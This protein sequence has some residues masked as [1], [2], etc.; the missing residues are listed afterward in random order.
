MG[1]YSFGAPRSLIAVYS[2]ACTAKSSSRH[3]PKVMLHGIKRLLHA[4]A[5]RCG[6]RLVAHELLDQRILNAE[7]SV[8]LQIL[9]AFDEQ[10]R[11]HRFVARR[12]YDHVRVCRAI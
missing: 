12:R 1:G 9:V 11:S 4:L 10:M 3:Q 2:R 5:V 7:H 8:G 6:A